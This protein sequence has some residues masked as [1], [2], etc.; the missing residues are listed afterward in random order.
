MQ[1]P[2]KDSKVSTLV[3]L[4]RPASPDV[5]A[6]ATASDSKKLNSLAGRKRKHGSMEVGRIHVITHIVLNTVIRLVNDRGII[7]GN[8]RR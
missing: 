8:Q 1:L 6:P 5:L 7:H 2:R 3:K 4:S